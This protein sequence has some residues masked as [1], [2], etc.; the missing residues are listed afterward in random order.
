MNVSASKAPA[1][2]STQ[3]PTQIQKQAQQQA[4]I[5]ERPKA[6][7]VKKPD[8]TPAKPVVNTQGHTTGRL[9]NVTA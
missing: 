5:H 8:P 6:P 3:Q 2:Q 4:Q 9:V 1:V 7:E